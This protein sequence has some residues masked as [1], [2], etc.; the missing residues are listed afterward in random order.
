M[1]VIATSSEQERFWRGE[2]GTSYAQRNRGS[3]WV[4][5]NTALFG[6]ILGRTQGVRSVLELGSSI[7]LNLMAIGHL[8][9]E[10]AISAV[11]INED[12]AAELATNL[13]GAEVHVMPIREF[14]PVRTWDLVF[15][16]GVLI[17]VNPDELPTVYDLMRRCSNRYLVVA[18]YYSPAPVEIEYR[19]HTGKLFKR[20]FAG[21]LLDRFPELR[22]V[23]Y[24]FA[25]HRDPNFPQDDLT[26]FVLEVPPGQH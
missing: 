2:F 24:G 7:G 18:E 22:L 14:E 11:E 15:T 23:D 20:D 5:A 4:A 21:A 12:A 13:P 10:A 25:Y 19:G 1:L 9:P 16:K 6:R 8:L 26:W 3:D 17:H